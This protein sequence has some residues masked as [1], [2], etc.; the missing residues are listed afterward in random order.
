[1]ASG[2]LPVATSS[3]IFSNVFRSNTVTVGLAV[4]DESAAEVARNGDSVDAM[5]PVDLAGHGEG[6]GVQHVHFHAM[7][8]KYSPALRVHR[9]V[10]PAASAAYGNFSELMVVALANAAERT[11]RRVDR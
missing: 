5:Q 9:N 3:P 2:F 1:M 11:S 4:A 7:R 6:I 8:N 10:V